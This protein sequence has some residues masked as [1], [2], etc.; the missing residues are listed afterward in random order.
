MDRFSRLSGATKLVGISLVSLVAAVGCG[1]GVPGNT[2]NP[3]RGMDARNLPDADA[4]VDSA[5]GDTGDGPSRDL[6][7]SDRTDTAASDPPLEQSSPDATDVPSGADAEAGR[8]L[9]GPVVC[10]AAADCPGTDTE[11]S[12]RTCVQGTCGTATLAVG[13]PVPLQIN[14]D[15][16][17]RQCDAQ[18]QVVAV[19]DNFDLPA[20]GNPCTLDV[21]TAGAP[22]HTSAPQG[23]ACGGTNKCNASGQCVG[24]NVAAD[25]PGD[26]TA[27][28][29]RTCTQGVCGFNRLAT[30]TAIASQ[31]VGDCKV[32]QCDGQGNTT[33]VPDNSD[34]PVD[35]NACTSDVC[36]SGTPSNPAA[37]SGTM[38]GNG[39]QCDGAGHC[40]QCNVAADCGLSNDCRTY[41]CT[42]QGTCQV[43]FKNAGTALTTQAGGD[44][45]VAQ[46]DGQGNT[47]QT[48]D[49]T[50]KPVDG[51]PCTK[52]VCTTG[53][54]SNPPESTDVACGNNQKCDG[55][56]HCLGCGVASDC[57][58]D[59]ACRTFS[60]SSQVCGSAVAAQG[61]VLP[62]QS[63]TDHDCKQNQCDGNGNVVAVSL[64]SDK[65]ADDGNVCTTEGCSSGTA[66][67]TPASTATA[68]TANGGTHCNGA[69]VCVA[70]T[71]A[72]TFM[73]LRVGDG[74]APTAKAA[75]AAVFIE[76]RAVSD[77]ALVGTP[78]ALPTFAS[79]GSNKPVMLSN[80][81]KSEGGLSLSTD[82]H[83]LTL[84][85]YGPTVSPG[86]TDAV[87]S[88][89]AERVVARI[90]AAGVVE[91][92]GLT[93]SAF[94]ADNLRGV[95]S[96]N[97]TDLWASGNGSTKSGGVWYAKFGTTTGLQVLGS[98]VPPNSPSQA[99]LCGLSA[100]GS[101]LYCSS[102]R[103][104][105]SGIFTVGSSPPPTI[106]PM[107]IA[108]LLTAMPGGSGP[109]PF[110][111]VFIGSNKLYVTDD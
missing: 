41:T 101:I 25:C 89:P 93:A 94:I 84:G 74:T 20:D 70:D 106:T 2:D 104:D 23:Q 90:S 40:G 60:C 82:G 111:F 51:N 59:T 7:A 28:Q 31:V 107:Q 19:A 33:T 64:D 48:P 6:V 58:Q 38:C 62:N 99:R 54:P 16:K 14:G 26:N 69:G 80:S 13:L 44:C 35:G 88:S 46:C 24:C 37:A 63:Q 65:P 43:V 11:C 39:R 21:C 4:K 68:C 92:W 97:G 77:G 27:C 98:G 95:T 91:T 50:D 30:G 53:T 32:V 71:A 22:S 34:K 56:G 5:A 49:D 3:G 61:T 73:A 18:G 110:A 102:D 12:K 105:Y 78:I 81:A 36:T 96:T 47:M 9:S 1:N 15:C 83:Y 52:D 86:E 57:G 42:A 76:T 8:D 29:T 45:K 85:G 100:T 66:T 108:T 109:S 87:A 79:H 10:T 103:K 17:V 67:S 72:P 55:S 75:A